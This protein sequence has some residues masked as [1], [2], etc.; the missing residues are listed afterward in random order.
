[1]RT[2][3]DDMVDDASARR[4][5]SFAIA[6]ETAFIEITGTTL[7]CTHERSADDVCCADQR[8][9]AAAAMIQNGWWR[10]LQG[11]GLQI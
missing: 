5:T 1:M 6:S 11:R 9:N 7:M 2:R 10:G 8:S 4:D 3:A